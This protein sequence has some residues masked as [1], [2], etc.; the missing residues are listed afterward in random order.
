[1]VR[2]RIGEKSRKYLLIIYL[3]IYIIYV[4]NIIHSIRT[5]YT[6]GMGLLGTDGHMADCIVRHPGVE[7]SFSS[8]KREPA[9]Y[10][11]DK[12]SDSLKVF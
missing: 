6:C 4:Y 8:L 5:H 1:M 3:C 11:T 7:R 9:D 2:T 10:R 12:V